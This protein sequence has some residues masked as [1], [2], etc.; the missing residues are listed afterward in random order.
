MATVAATLPRTRRSR[1]PVRASSRQMIF[2]E[3]YFVKRIDNSRL[4]REVDPVKRRECFSLL[5][6]C[7]L[8][9]FS[10]L[11]FAWQHFQCVQYGYR[12]EQL[13]TQKS[14]MEDWNHQLRLEHASLADPQRIDRLARKELGLASPGPDQVIRVGPEGQPDSSVLARNMPALGGSQGSLGRGQ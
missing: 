5:G 10:G 4:R 12:I 1:K 3:F 9:F 6:L 13:K 8:V 11:V 2:P 14:T 7:L